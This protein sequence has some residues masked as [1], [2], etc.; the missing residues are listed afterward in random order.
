MLLIKTTW[1]ESY[2]EII[3]NGN[4]VFMSIEIE[5]VAFGKETVD[6]ILIDMLLYHAGKFA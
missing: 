6:P 1:I 5:K 3:Q 4:R 2:K